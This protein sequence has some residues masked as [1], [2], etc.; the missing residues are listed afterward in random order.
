VT[1]PLPALVCALVLAPFARA[2]AA[3]VPKHLMP[4]GTAVAFPT[5]VGTTWEYEGNYGQQV[6]V[7]SDVT[8]NAD[9]SKLVTTEYVR[10]NGTRA[11]HMVRRVSPEGLFLVAESGVKYAEPWCLLKLPHEPGQVW[12]T[13][14]RRVN[15]GSDSICRTTAGPVEKVRVGAG[16][17]V[18]V[19]VDREIP[20][21]G[22]RARYWYAS[23]V[24]MVRLDDDMKLKSF[25]PGKGHALFGGELFPVPRRRR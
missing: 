22:M 21:G 13:N 8:E 11:A 10:G 6:I 24:G 20:R 19:R 7:I 3:P 5:T 12:E 25:A 14:S 18:A 17:F 15:E 16:E 23:S 2:P 1:R 9:G 4:K